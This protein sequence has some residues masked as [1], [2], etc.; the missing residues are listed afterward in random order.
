MLSRLFQWQPQLGNTA[1]TSGVSI[2][3][4]NISELQT[5]KKT[6]LQQNTLLVIDQG[7]FPIALRES[8]TLMC[9]FPIML[10][11]DNKLRFDSWLGGLPQVLAK[12][13]GLQDVTDDIGV[14]RLLTYLCGYNELFFP[15]EDNIF[16]FHSGQAD[17]AIRDY[18]VRELQQRSKDP[19]VL[20]S[21]DPI[22]DL[23]QIHSVPHTLMVNIK[24]MRHNRRI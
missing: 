24:A 23:R 17:A 16:V 21:E 22:H 1:N 2:A 3:V 10:L 18:A 8:P 5:H 14:F 11:R 20:I 7:C 12:M 13:S 15:S 4:L 19:L 9:S 6:L